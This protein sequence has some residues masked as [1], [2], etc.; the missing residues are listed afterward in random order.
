M[1]KRSPFIEF[2]KL[3]VLA[4]DVDRQEIRMRMPMRPELER[5]HASNMFHGGPIASFID[6]V[7]DYAVVLA[8]DKPV[9]TINLRVDYVRPCIGDYIDAVAITRRVGRTIAVVDVDVIDANG[10]LCAVGRG[11]YGV[12]Q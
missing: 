1:L 9:P 2:L 4:V 12:P 8:T 6:T 10:K 3:E 11:S 7:G 5:G